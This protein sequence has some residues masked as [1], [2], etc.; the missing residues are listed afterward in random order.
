M[1]SS[2]RLRFRA[3]T[4]VFLL[5]A[6]GLPAAI[7]NSSNSFGYAVF[8]TMINTLGPTVLAAF[9]G[10]TS[11]A[12]A[13]KVVLRRDPRGSSLIKGNIAAMLTAILAIAILVWALAYFPR[14]AEVGER[15]AAERARIEREVPV[16]PSRADAMASW[17]WRGSTGLTTV[18][19]RPR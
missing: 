6:V 12:N 16:G 14:P 9:F 7:T 11:A 5:F 4:V 15:F 19:R 18:M 8:Q 17:S 2:K 1:H 10:H 13:A 3:W